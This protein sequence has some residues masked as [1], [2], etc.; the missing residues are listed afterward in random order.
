MEETFHFIDRYGFTLVAAVAMAIAL[1]RIVMFALV[2]KAAQFAES[3]RELHEMQIKVLER[4]TEIEKEFA[5]MEGKLDIISEYVKK[6][7]ME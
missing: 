6:K 7:M 1:Y 3:H 2:G 4:L 5:T